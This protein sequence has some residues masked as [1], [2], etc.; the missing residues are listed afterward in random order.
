M[1]NPI[2][3]ADSTLA[4]A[5]LFSRDCGVRKTASLAMQQRSIAGIVVIKTPFK[6]R[7]LQ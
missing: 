6:I 7:T 2:T 1:S 3:L 5:S 4:E